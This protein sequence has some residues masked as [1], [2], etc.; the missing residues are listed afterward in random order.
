MR[1]LKPLPTLVRNLL[2][3][4]LCACVSTETLQQRRAEKAEKEQIASL[5]A[6]NKAQHDAFRAT[7]NWKSRVFQDEAV[8]AIAK[9]TNMRVHI[10]LGEQ[11]GYFLVQD[12]IGYDFPVSTGRKSHRTPTG[13]FKIIGKERT[14]RSNLYGRILDSAGNVSVSNADAKKH[15]VEAGDIFEG[16][17]MPYFMRLTNGGVGMHIGQLPGYAASHGCIRLPKSV[18]PKLYKIAPIGTPVSVTET[19][20]AK[21]EATSEV[22]AD[23]K[24]ESK[25]K[26]KS[27]A[28]P[29][30]KPK[31][32]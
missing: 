23:G 6:T 15:K 5:K 17:S 32:A 9:P 1:L 3:L 29:T 22:K 25:K 10:V 26:E 7:K 18:A 13:D 20:E 31:V 8:V 21:V 11:R 30:P 28:K 27:Q 4:L 14:H 2:P 12:L 16:A 24:P 19:R